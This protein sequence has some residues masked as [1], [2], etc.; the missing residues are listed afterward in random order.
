MNK[1][2]IFLKILLFFRALYESIKIFLLYLFLILNI[3]NI[4]N[5]FLLSI[6]FF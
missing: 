4:V 2:F 5:S 6:I 3:K 1:I